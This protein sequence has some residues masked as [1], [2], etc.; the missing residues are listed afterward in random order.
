MGLPAVMF[1]RFHISLPITQEY[2]Q[3][4]RVTIC[5]TQDVSPSMLLQVIVLVVYRYLIQSRKPNHAKKLNRNPNDYR[6]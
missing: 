1:Y 4:C 5:I 2:G 3:R 6:F